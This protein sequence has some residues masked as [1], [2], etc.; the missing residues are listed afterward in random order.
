[1]NLQKDNSE[2]SDT[3]TSVTITC[4]KCGMIISPGEVFKSTILYGYVLLTGDDYYWLGFNC[5]KCPSANLIIE[6]YLNDSH[7]KKDTF[8]GE[9]YNL[10][11]EPL[12]QKDDTHIK[13]GSYIKLQWV[14]NSFPYRL[15][16]DKNNPGLKGY[17]RTQF[18]YT[19]S[20]FK[21]IFF[22]PNIRNATH[23]C[24]KNEYYPCSYND[25]YANTGPAISIGYYKNDQIMLLAEIESAKQ[26]KA[27]YRFMPYDPLYTTIQN[28]CWNNRILIEFQK[29]I[30]PNSPIERILA[31]D[32]KA[33][34]TKN[35]DFMLLL[36]EVHSEDLH[37]YVDNKKSINMIVS[38]ANSSMFKHNSD[39]DQLAAS[40]H[41]D[42]SRII[43]DN[44]SK[45]YVQ[46]LLL[47]HADMFIDEYIDLS[48]RNDFSY[49]DAWNLKEEYL[50]NIADA[51]K[52]PSKRGKTKAEISIFYKKMAED[53]EKRVPAL[54]KILSESDSINELKSKISNYSQLN[55]DKHSV[56]LLGETGTGKELFAKA[57]HD[58]SGR[59]GKFVPVDCGSL[60][61]ELFE[62]AIFGHVE[63]A[64]TGAINN[65]N[66][67]FEDAGNG[68]VFLDEIGNVPLLL[69][70][71]LLRLLNNYEYS[72]VGSN[73]VKPI[74]AMIIFATSKN[75]LKEYEDG[76]FK[77]DLYYR[78]EKLKFKIP[79]LRERVKDIPLL[80]EYFINRY[81]SDDRFNLL[82]VTPE[83]M[84]ALR[85]YKWDGNIRQLENFVESTVDM[86]VLS[87][88]I[89]PIELR[90]FAEY[91][92]DESIACPVSKINK[93]HPSSNIPKLPGNK[94][95][96]DDQI[97]SAME[98]SN[99]NKTH[100]GSLLGVRYKTILRR[101]KKINI[102]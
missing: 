48:M 84:D 95:L 98:Q 44:F 53:A 46:N 82:S 45:D 26:Q 72:P 18:P 12:L 24:D 63:G 96:T 62:S 27:F 50:K 97:I 9:L 102:E 94:K 34:L 28:F 22:N 91:T 41:R 70:D 55:K 54:K 89:R 64:F 10:M 33:C 43:W 36:D 57:I 60:S 83:C 51:I 101:W 31:P 61:K 19:N 75:L 5:P 68:T 4:S 90:D 20:V 92:S 16:L 1:M 23:N 76:N 65:K 39:K 77:K 35:V 30:L 3:D 52:Y 11:F 14:Y 47:A 49:I 88:E 8:I 81:K 93:M 13:D 2:G 15:S 59:T 99:G 6:K 56:L 74:N 32:S 40:D 37:H 66:S 25:T 17:Y 21:E 85:N 67:P 71:K 78:I 79:P 73:V 87:E 100:A 69:Q 86:Q 58:A 29:E 7:L 80:L 42:F 38:S